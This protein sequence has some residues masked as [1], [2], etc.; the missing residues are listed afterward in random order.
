MISDIFDFRHRDSMIGQDW[1]SRVDLA[2][3]KI[4]DIKGLGDNGSIY[5]DISVC[6]YKFKSGCLGKRTPFPF[7]CTL[8]YHRVL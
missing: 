4:V 8:I 7:H 6:Q 2:R 1:I 3:V 5:K